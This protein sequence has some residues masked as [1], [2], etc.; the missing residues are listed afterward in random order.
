MQRSHM[1]LQWDEVSVYVGC[2]SGTPEILWQRRKRAEVLEVQEE[3]QQ[4]LG[5][6]DVN[7]ILFIVPGSKILITFVL[8]CSSS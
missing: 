5:E 6:M 2:L 7:G 8:G 4:E 1:G 3:K